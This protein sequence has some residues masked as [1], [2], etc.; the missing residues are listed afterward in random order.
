MS[1]VLM[2]GT[3]MHVWGCKCRTPFEKGSFCGKLGLRAVA[4]SGNIANCCRHET[5]PSS[6]NFSSLDPS[7][8]K[9]RKVYMTGPDA[10]ML[11]CVQHQFTR[12]KSTMSTLVGLIMGA[13]VTGSSMGQRCIPLSVLLYKWQTLELQDVACFR[14]EF[15][16]EKRFKA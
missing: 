10:H 9:T 12:K 6:R 13:N 15:S 1:T 3:S 2:L 16:R 11:F 5:S 7:A 4:C 8:Q 14:V